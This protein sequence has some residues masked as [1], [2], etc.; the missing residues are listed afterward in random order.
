MRRSVLAGSLS[1]LLLFLLPV[2]AGPQSAAAAVPDY[3]AKDAGYHSY[4][5][6]VRHIRQVAAA[7]DATC[8]QP[9]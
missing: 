2:A 1:A 5:E 3:P 6:M 7:M 4:P 8:G 9:R